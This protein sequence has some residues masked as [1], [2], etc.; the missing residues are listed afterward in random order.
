MKKI[1]LLLA[2]VI[3][4]SASGTLFAVVTPLCHPDVPTGPCV[5]PT[6]TQLI[7]ICIPYILRLTVDPDSVN[8]AIDCHDLGP[9]GYGSA[10][11][12]G[13]YHVATNM[14]NQKITGKI[15]TAMPAGTVLKTTLSAVPGST[16]LG[17]KVLTTV[18]VNLVQGITKVNGTGSINYLLEATYVADPTTTSRIATYTITSM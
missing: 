11:A 1:V 7:N 15:N 16:S 8:L 5:Q 12:T 4:I 18:P 3:M 6:D 13:T 10:T 2:A 17:Q 14:S 9:D